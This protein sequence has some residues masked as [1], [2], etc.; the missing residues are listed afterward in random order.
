MTTYAFTAKPI[1]KFRDTWYATYNVYQKDLG[2]RAR[3]Q[4]FDGN[5]LVRESFD[6]SVKTK[7]G[8]TI[9]RFSVD[10]G[11]G[12]GCKVDFDHLEKNHV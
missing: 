9:P 1:N 7:Q 5:R 12:S 2:L 10:V 4:L 8:R 3:G 6:V 11:T